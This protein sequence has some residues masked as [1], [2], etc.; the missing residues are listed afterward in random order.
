[1]VAWELAATS[2]VTH[3]LQRGIALQA[4]PARQ[5]HTPAEQAMR[6]LAAVRMP[7]GR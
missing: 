5:A 2:A 1:L 3:H 4:I 7:V 6:A